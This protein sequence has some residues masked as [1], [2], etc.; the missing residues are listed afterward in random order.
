VGLARALVRDADCLLLDE[1]T[2]H[3]D[4]DGEAEVVEALSGRLRGRSGIVV[5]H[6]P[7]VLPLADRVL[8]LE[9]GRL[10]EVGPEHALDAAEPAGG[11]RAGGAR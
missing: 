5:T 2:A 3:L 1:P 7:A 4:P 6:R 10:R 9:A 11:R 8:R